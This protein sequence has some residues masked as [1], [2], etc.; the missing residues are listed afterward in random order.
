MK[1]PALI[2]LAGWVFVVGASTV[3]LHSQ[4]LP[5]PAK[6]P[7]RLIDHNPFQDNPT[8]AKDLYVANVAQLPE[9]SLVTL[10]SR[11]DPEFRKYLFA[12]EP[13]DGLHVVS[14]MWSETRCQTRVVIAKG[15]QVATLGFLDGCAVV[16]L[17]EPPQY[18]LRPWPF[19]LL[20]PDDYRNH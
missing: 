18:I 11:V 6:F 15:A 5:E 14:V 2:I 19:S 7:Q 16:F 12:S 20:T 8:F 10:A 1:H 13:E 17:K 9:G 4:T 3:A